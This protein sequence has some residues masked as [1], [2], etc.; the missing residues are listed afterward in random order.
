MAKAKRTLESDPPPFSVGTP[1]AK[2]ATVQSVPKTGA[3]KT[4]SDPPHSYATHDFVRAEVAAM[5]SELSGV[6][7]KLDNKIDLRPSIWWLLPVFGAILVFGYGFVRDSVSDSTRQTIA[8]IDKRM[9]QSPSASPP[10]DEKLS[11]IIEQ[12]NQ[13]IRLLVSQ[14]EQAA[15]EAP[16]EEPKAPD[17][18]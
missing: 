7:G 14:Q 15:A 10:A 1:R 18:N 16:V 13:L 11:T 2:R 4:I 3:D 9:S 12:N 5:K 17:R 6:I 8:E